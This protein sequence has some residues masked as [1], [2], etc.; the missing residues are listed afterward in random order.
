MKPRED[1][2]ATDIQEN[3]KLKIQHEYNHTN[4]RNRQ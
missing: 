1:L 4:G 3:N 2:E